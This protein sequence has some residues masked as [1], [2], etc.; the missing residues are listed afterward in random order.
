MQSL[1][2]LCI[3]LKLIFGYNFKPRLFSLTWRGKK[4]KEVPCRYHSFANFLLRVLILPRTKRTKRDW[5]DSLLTKLPYTYRLQH[6]LGH[7][8]TNNTITTAMHHPHR[9]YLTHHLLLEEV[10]PKL[11]VAEWCW[12][13]KATAPTAPPQTPLLITCKAWTRTC[14]T[15]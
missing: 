4:L 14:P 3:T 15:P 2:Q 5:A 1:T 8:N 10:L 6:H 9:P 11:V 7:K 13:L 12:V